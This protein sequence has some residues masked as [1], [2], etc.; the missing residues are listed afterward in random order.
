MTS[1]PRVA[2]TR[3]DYHKQQTLWPREGEERQRGWLNGQESEPGGIHFGASSCCLNSEPAGHVFLSKNAAVR[4][5]SI[6]LPKEFGL[7]RLFEPTG[8]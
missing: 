2:S 4:L 1:F 6:L 8:P 3:C 7:E 5:K